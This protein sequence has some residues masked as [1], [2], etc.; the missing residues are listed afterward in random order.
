VARAGDLLFVAGQCGLLEDNSIAGADV[1]DQTVQA[2]ENV[3]T[4]LESQGASLRDVVKFI[5]YLT[6]A[7]DVPAFYAARDQC[8]AEHY[9]D[10]DYPP[11]TL[12]IVASLVQPRL[13]VEIEATAYRP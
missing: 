9:P 2:Y 4:A 11:N 7:G 3:R 8:F 10:G 6:N 13:L 1:A 5:S 12:I